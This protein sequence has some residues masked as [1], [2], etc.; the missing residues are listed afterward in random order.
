MNIL[1]HDLTTW[2][3]FCL[4]E[5]APLTQW[6]SQTLSPSPVKNCT[7]V[8][9]CVAC[10]TVGLPLRVTQVLVRLRNSLFMI[11]FLFQAC[12]PN[13]VAVLIDS[14]RRGRRRRLIKCHAKHLISLSNCSLIQL[15]P[16][17]GYRQGPFTN[18]HHVVSLNLS[19]ITNAI[20][21]NKMIAYW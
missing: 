4:V 1:I 3:S 5:Y 10:K 18:G 14:R 11:G 2:Q 9:S 16:H 20:D 19:S 13:K 8:W 6:C 12:H 7:F 21:V 15:L 17:A